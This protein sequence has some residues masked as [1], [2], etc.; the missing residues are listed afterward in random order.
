MT[1][2]QRHEALANGLTQQEIDD[3]EAEDEEFDRITQPAGLE[4]T[5]KESHERN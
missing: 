4:E 3:M 2:A 5:G 1:P